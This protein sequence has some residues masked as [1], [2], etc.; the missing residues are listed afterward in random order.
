[1]KKITTRKFKDGKMKTMKELIG[2]YRGYEYKLKIVGY[3]IS[4]RKVDKPMT[5]DRKL[6]SPLHTMVHQCG[7]VRLKPVDYYLPDQTD[8]IYTD[9][10]VDEWFLYYYGDID[11]ITFDRK[12][13][14]S[15]GNGRWIGIDFAHYQHLINPA[16]YIDV[17]KALKKII[18]TII[19]ARQELSKKEAI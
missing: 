6:E 14:F 1:M 7:Y 11:D 15:V 10:E 18:D 2:S 17:V 19:K 9:D 16:S 3:S 5:R 13:D 12:D 4:D 8:W